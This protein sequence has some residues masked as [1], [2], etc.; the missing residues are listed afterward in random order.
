[1]FI[2]VEI[3]HWVLNVLF[4]SVLPW[5]KSNHAFSSAFMKATVYW[6][7]FCF[8]FKSSSAQHPV[9]GVRRAMGHVAVKA[10]WPWRENTHTGIHRRVWVRE[11]KRESEKELYL[12]ILAR[13][14]FKLT[15]ELA[16]ISRLL[17]GSTSCQIIVPQARLTGKQLPGAT[18]TST[19]HVP[20]SS[21]PTTIQDQWGR[22]S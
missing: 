18:M 14:F 15:N 20:I 22:N 7:S 4:P 10:T 1:M 3:N 5:K 19:A 2:G 13:S 17:M 11:H 6:Y 21:L 9:Y 16:K 8:I 12:V